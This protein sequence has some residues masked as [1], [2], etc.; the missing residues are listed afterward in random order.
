MQLDSYGCRCL[1]PGGS[2]EGLYGCKADVV[3][4]LA[5]QWL[6]A[7]RIADLQADI[8]CACRINGQL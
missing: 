3:P 8:L 4:G 7:R 5:S 1:K 6:D 2:L